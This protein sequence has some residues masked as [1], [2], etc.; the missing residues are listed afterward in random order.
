M[1]SRQATSRATVLLPEPP[2][3]STAKTSA[4]VVRDCPTDL[5]L[6]TNDLTDTRYVDGTWPGAAP[7]RVPAHI[8][9]SV[10]AVGGPPRLTELRQ[11]PRGSRRCHREFED[12]ARCFPAV[13]HA[14]VLDVA[15]PLADR[16]EQ[17]GELARPVGHDDAHP[18]PLGERLP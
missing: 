5:L 15:P 1:V 8:S 17:R 6:E 14:D 10:P 13:L 18:R 3:P 9:P 11:Q 16:V 4:S 7:A 12:A 2:G